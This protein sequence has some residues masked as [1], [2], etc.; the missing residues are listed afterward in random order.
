MNLFSLSVAVS[1]A[2][3]E[4]RPASLV[5][6]TAME[7]LPETLAEEAERKLPVIRKEQEVVATVLP[8]YERDIE[9]DWFLLLDVPTRKLSFAP[10]GTDFISRVYFVCCFLLEHLLN[11]LST[12]FGLSCRGN[13]VS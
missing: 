10:P 6:A 11:L 1:Q 9:D 8:P 2:R 5:K 7:Q 12:V 13:K 4:E 3:L